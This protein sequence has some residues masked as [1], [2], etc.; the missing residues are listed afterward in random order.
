MKL[1][2]VAALALLTLAGCDNPKPRHVPPDPMAK[3]PA[4]APA[5]APPA[6]GVTDGLA[7]RTEG[8][9]FSLDRVGEALDPLNKQPAGTPGDAPIVLSGFG[10]DP[11]AKAPATGIEVAIDGKA[12]AATY[13]LTRADV[14]AYFKTPALAPTGFTVTLP[15]GFLINGPHQVAVRV[16][17]ADGKGYFES[18]Q[19]PFTVD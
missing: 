9:A 16:I 19:V 5:I 7:K 12:Y 14:G 18:P 8:A 4:A 10:F 11:V 17:A 13:G 3:A 2:A 6:D 1:H 15:A